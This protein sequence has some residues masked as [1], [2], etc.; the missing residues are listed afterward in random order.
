[1][2]RCDFM[3]YGELVCL[4]AL[5]SSDLED[6]MKNWNDWNLRSTIGVPLP[7]SESSRKEW[8][9]EAMTSSPSKN[10][11]LWLA[12]TDKKKG[13]FLG[14]AGLSNIRYPHHR[15]RLSISIYDQSNRSKGYGTDGT[16]VL[17]WIGFHILNL[18]S[19]SLDTFPGNEAAVRAYEK[20]GFK[21]VGL[22]RNTEFMGGEFHDLLLMDVIRSEFLEKYPAGTQVG[23][24][25]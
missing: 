15:A 14:H 4:R 9:N 12:V 13:S 25:P 23:D 20:A 3:Y 24:A 16:R 7:H 11:A 19:I 22:L 18:E 2:K 1:M 21:K 10:G 5:E 6:I 17:L 8:L